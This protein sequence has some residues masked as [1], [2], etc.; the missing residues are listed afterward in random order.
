MKLGFLFSFLLVS[1]AYAKGPNLSQV[2]EGELNGRRMRIE[3]VSINTDTGSVFRIKSCTI[4]GPGGTHDCGYNYAQRQA[5]R[6]QM[7]NCPI[8]NG[9]IGSGQCRYDANIIRTEMRWMG[10][11]NAEAHPWEMDFAYLDQDSELRHVYTVKTGARN[12]ERSISVKLGT[13]QGGA[14]FVLRPVP[15][16]AA[17]GQAGRS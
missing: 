9:T 17:T 14:E 4:S 13:E 6:S 7:R 16:P 1:S 5:H 15:T 12:E 11:K 8:R 2:Y 10:G 3:F